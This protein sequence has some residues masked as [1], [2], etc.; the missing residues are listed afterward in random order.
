M[1]K[2][3]QSIKKGLFFYEEPDKG[4]V[5]SIKSAKNL[6]KAAT[7]VRDAGIKR[8][9]CFT[10]FPL[11][12][13]EKAMGIEKSWDKSSYSHWWDYWCCFYVFFCC[14]HTSN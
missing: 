12:G 4:Y 10:P 7:I 6:L 8:F 13:M 3:I 5:A 11:H 2:I 9:D 1:K 14:I